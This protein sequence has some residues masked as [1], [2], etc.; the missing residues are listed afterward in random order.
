MDSI[1]RLLQ[2]G[3]PLAGVLAGFSPRPE[4]LDMARRVTHAIATGR[5]L[6]VEAGAGTGK[7]IAYLLPALYCERK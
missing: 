3:S 1:E 4:Q 2:D 5:H 7:T 6:A